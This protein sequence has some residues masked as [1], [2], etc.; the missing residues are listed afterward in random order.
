MKTKIFIDGSEGTT[1][2]RI[3][4]RFMGREDIEILSISQ[5]LRKD[6]EE[7]RRLINSSDISILCLPDAAARESVSLIENESVR[8]IDTSTAHRTK[9]DWSY[10]FP[11][12]SAKHRQAV[13][14]GKRIA[15]PGCHATGFIS[16]LYPIV[17]EGILSSEY[18]ISG[19]SITGYSGGGKSMIAQYED[20]NRAEEFDSPREYALSQQHK[21]LKEVKKI[22]GLSREPLFSPIVADYYSGMVVSVPVYTEFLKGCHTPDKLRLFFNDYYAGQKLIRVMPQSAEEE[23]KGMM[24][25]NGCSGWD[26]LKLY[27]T[28]NEERAVLTAQFDNLG[29]GASGAAIQCLN[30][31]LGCEEEKGLNL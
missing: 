22:A 21:H 17:S 14:K 6:E 18:P 12:L 15:V 27:V 13:E 24:A 26:G 23:I 5:E 4:E 28:G 31:M 3:H 20:E 11:E 7:R 10:G 1:G 8:I 29:K 9:D 30:I 2:L 16:L 25:G 19:F